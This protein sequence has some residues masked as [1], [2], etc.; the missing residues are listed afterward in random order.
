MCHH[1]AKNKT[2]PSV[3][4]LFTQN[5]IQILSG[6]HAIFLT[7]SITL[8]FSFFC[9][10][11]DAPAFAPAVPSAWETLFSDS[12]VSCSFLLFR[13][14]FRCHFLRQVFP[15]LPI[16]EQHIIHLTTLT[17]IYFSLYFFILQIS[18]ECA[19]YCPRCWEYNTKQNRQK[20][21]SFMEHYFPVWRESINKLN[22]MP[23]E[24][25]LYGE[26]QSREA[27]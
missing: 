16:K 1:S 26:N 23:D 17:L 21:L 13:F 24:N 10:S 12:Y 19:R 3:A 8:L 22:S 7:Y 4:S 15:S 6:T 9:S 20:S 11:Q 27:R 18:F 25:R 2:K 14:L 5:K